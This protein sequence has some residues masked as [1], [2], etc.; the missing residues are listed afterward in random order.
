MEGTSPLIY[1]TNTSTEFS[2]PLSPFNYIQPDSSPEP[3][4]NISIERQNSKNR[5]ASKTPVVRV[6]L[7]LALKE[8]LTNQTK[9]I[10][11][12]PEEKEKTENL[13]DNSGAS[14]PTQHSEEKSSKTEDLNSELKKDKAR[15]FIKTGNGKPHQRCGS[16][17]SSKQESNSNYIVPSAKKVKKF[18]IISRVKA[19]KNLETSTSSSWKTSNFNLGARKTQLLEYSSH[20]TDY[21][22]KGNVSMPSKSLFKNSEYKSLSPYS[23]SLTFKY[24]IPKNSNKAD[25]EAQEIQ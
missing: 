17:D 6:H 14:I 13:Q 23:V 7:S 24:Q 4:V 1:T 11:K 22:S 16:Q 2:D 25:E 21:F 15:S 18:N 20:D 12:N 8:N 10:E 9:A 19:G 5:P 3:K